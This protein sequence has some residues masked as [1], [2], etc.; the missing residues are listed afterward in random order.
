[1]FLPLLLAALIAY[2]V[3]AG[4]FVAAASGTNR[5]A[6]WLGLAALAAAA[7]VFSWFGAF[8]E[9]FESGQCYTQAIT[10]IARAIENTDVPKALAEKVRTLPLHGYET[11]CSEVEA[12]AHELPNAAAP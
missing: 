6:K 3:F 10:M 2:V 7:P 9:Q 8:S 4:L 11:N 12:A 1:M 5:R